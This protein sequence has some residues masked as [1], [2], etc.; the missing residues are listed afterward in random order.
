MCR[1]AGLI[2][3][4]L[5]ASTIRQS[6]QLMADVQAHGGPDD[7]GFYVDTEHG[8][9]LAHRRLSLLD[10]SAAGR[11]PMCSPDN[12]VVLVFNG[13]I[14]NF[15]DLKGKLS[16]ERI[17][18]NTQTDSEVII[19]AYQHW[20]TDA[21]SKLKGMFAF[22]LYDRVKQE[23]YL[24]RDS[25][26]IKPLYVYQ[27]QKIIAFASEVKAF[28]A[29]KLPLSAN[30]DWPIALLS[31]G[32]LPEPLTTYQEVRMMPK[33]TFTTFSL[34]EAE[35]RQEVQCLKYEKSFADLQFESPQTAINRL[36]DK[37]IQSQLVADAPIGVFLS[38]GIDSSLLALQAAKHQ[39]E[40]LIT[41]SLN[42]KEKQFSESTFQQTISR[43]LPGA[44]H[45]KTVDEQLFAAYFDGI[46]GNMDQP[47]VDGINTWFVSQAAKEAGLTAVLSGVGADE[48]FGGYPSFRRMPYIPFLR[49]FSF[50][51]PLATQVTHNEGLKRWTYLN[52]KNPSFE[53]LFLRGFFDPRQL[54][55]F[56]SIHRNQ[57]IASLQH[58]ALAQRQ[59]PKNY[60][61]KRAAWFEQNYFMQNQLL[62]DTDS[63]SMQHGLEIRVPF[64]DEDLVH[65]VNTL[66]S[67][68]LF[69][70]NKPAK[71]FLVHAFDDLL[72]EMIW[73]RPKMGFTFPFQFWL[74]RHPRYLSLKDRYTKLSDLYTAFE[75]DQIHWSKIMALLVMEQFGGFELLN[76]K[77]DA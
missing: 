40:K 9:G 28:S 55:N 70:K 73:K 36:L 16:A 47:G 41:V 45:S 34:E 27:H 30:T 53:Y 69:P 72:P 33:G 7:E 58:I 19:A 5:S 24:V 61:A 23:I 43:L 20:G 64:L 10:L 68:I 54:K 50:L 39:K 42:F 32:H 15:R 60:D 3:S 67:N 75:R 65:Y 31:M 51:A 18:F 37:A 12:Q 49:T 71:H 44:H 52:E 48:L 63:M 57:Q 4:S 22:A 17:A 66:P 2:R 21:F 59:I 35:P 11:Q 26:G 6:L 62:K 8:L 29:A 38:G 46:L 56:F 74:K 14:Y 13:E 76:D 1:I 25:Q 77:R